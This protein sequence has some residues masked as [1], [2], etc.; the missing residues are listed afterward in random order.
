MADANLQALLASRA[1]AHGGVPVG[2]LL[3]RKQQVQSWRELLQR[4]LGRLKFAA[5]DAVAHDQVLVHLPPAAAAALDD[6]SCAPEALRVALAPFLAQTGARYFSGVRVMDGALGRAT[7]IPATGATALPAA[8]SAAAI[9]LTAPSTTAIPAA[10][11]AP[12]FTFAEVFAGIGGFR[13]GLELL[14]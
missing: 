8:P 3:L 1:S 2:V 6:P 13:L 9:L 12:R 7:A 5:V 11:R 14:G 4:H 10:S